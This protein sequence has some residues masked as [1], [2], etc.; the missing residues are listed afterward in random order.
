[1]GQL[2]EARIFTKIDLRSAYNLVRVAEGHEWKTAFRTHYGLYEYLVMPFGLTNAPSVF[3]RLINDVLRE[4]ID[5]TCIVYLDDIL[6]Y[7]QDPAEHVKHV[8]QV[9]DKLR[10]NSLYANASKCEFDLK[11]VEYLGYVVTDHGLTMDNSKVQTIV[12]W[13]EPTSVRAV[14]LFLGFANFYRRFIRNY[15]AIAKPLTTLTRKDVKFEFDEN[16]AKAFAYLKKQFTTAPILVH[17]DPDKELI[18]ETDASDYAIGAVL[19]QVGDDQLQ[20]PIAFASRSMQTAELSYPIHDKEMLAIFW[21]FNEWRRYLLSSQLEVRVLTD[22][23]S[24]EYFMTSKILTRRQARWA[25]FF[26]EFNFTVY[27][28]PGKQA[29]KPDALSRRD[30]VYPSP[31]GTY[32][33]NNPFNNRP[34]LSQSRLYS[35]RTEGSVEIEPE[36]N[37]ED[38]PASFLEQVAKAQQQDE[39]LKLIIDGLQETKDPN[40][41]MINNVLHYQGLVYVP[42]DPKIKLNILRARHDAPSAG[43]PGR[44]KTMALIRRS[45]H[46]PGLTA[47]VSEYIDSCFECLRTKARRHQPYG[48]LQPLPIPNRPWS[49]L[50]MDFIG[51]LPKSGQLEF[52]SILVVVDRLT[53]MSIFIPTHTTLDA[54]GLAHL[55]L[56]HV[57]GRHGVPVNIVSDRGSLFTSAFFSALSSALGFHRLLS[58]AYH[59]E[60]DGQTERVNQILEQYLRIYTNYRQ[61]NWSDLLPLAEFAY[62]NSPHSAT[63]VSPFFANCGYHPTMSID[64]DSPG[65]TFSAD[66]DDLHVVHEHCKQELAKA[67]EAYANHANK[68]RIPFPDLAVGDRVWLSTR[69]LKTTRPTQKLSE[70]YIGP[71]KILRK[72]GKVAFELELPEEMRLLFP[73][74]HVSLLEPHKEDTI[75]GRHQDPPPPVEI[76]N[77]QPE[78]EVAEV[79]DCQLKGKG[80]ARKYKYKVLWAG[81]EHTAQATSWEPLSNLF[82]PDLIEHYHRQNPQKPKPPIQCPDHPNRCPKGCATR[83]IAG[84]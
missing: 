24:L 38:R 20:H 56:R 46:W 9:L 35:A 67:R 63:T 14:Q 43:H 41:S 11:Q 72:V 19:S 69:N 83:T 37:L 58:T 48:E 5:H 6:V 34:I 23:K 8:S 1:M 29:V 21:C 25:E 77:D 51:P 64:P 70:R 57:F 76:V 33:E 79:L 3:Q 17:F 18:V 54:P 39:K 4:H 71:F 42:D 15:S 81:Y 13:P 66:L 22:H 52:D 12:D 59:P 28:R 16:A 82:C 44:A 7:S 80:R 68:D 32:A 65:T 53:K 50:S 31:G 36:D 75:E 26:A 10:Q 27:Y 61:D 73:V 2:T 78:W 49:S 45:F 40:H 55:L 74:F 62:N 30:D 47:Y 84:K 60:T